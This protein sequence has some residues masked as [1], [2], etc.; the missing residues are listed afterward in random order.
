MNMNI[1]HLTDLHYGKKYDYNVDRM[2]PSLLKCL[3][4]LHSEN[5]IDFIVFSGDLIYS[6]S[7]SQYFSVVR[8]KIIL[9]LLD[10]LGLSIDQIFICAG[11]HD[12]NVEQEIP[13]IT[14]YVNK[15]DTND[16]LDEFYEDSKQFDLSYANSDNYF[17]FASD[18]YSSTDDNINKLSHVHL[19]KF[20]EKIIGFVS[21][22]TAWRSFIGNHSGE[23]LIP[24]K[25]VQDTIG[26][27]KDADFK[28]CLMHHPIS[29]LK[30]FNKYELETIITEKFHVLFTG[31]YHKKQQSIHLTHDFGLLSISS[32]ATMSGNDGSTIGFALLSIELD[33]YDVDIKNYTYA[34]ID[35]IFKETSSHL[36]QIPVND[37]KREQIKLLKEISR[38]ADDVIYDANDLLI[39]RNQELEEKN[40]NDIFSSPQLFNISF[41]ESIKD[42]GTA[43]TVSL[44]G[45]LEG[46]HVI[47]G[48]DKSGKS[49]LLRKLQI[50]ILRNFKQFRTIPIYIDCS[51]HSQIDNFD[52][53]LYCRNRF[54]LSRANT[55][56]LIKT[57]GF[58]LLLDNVNISSRRDTEFLKNITKIPFAKVSVILSTDESHTSYFGELRIDGISFKETFIHPINRTCIRSHANNLL[59]E[60]SDS[61]RN[62]IVERIVSVFS[63]LHIPFNYWTVS[64]FLW[65]YKKEKNLSIN[66]NVELINLYIDKL[67]GREEIALLGKDI[68]YKLIS[69]LL[70]DLS[71]ELISNH[72]D[73][74]YSMSYSDLVRFVEKFKENNIRFVSDEKNL[75]DHLIDKG[76]IKKKLDERYTFRLNGVMEYFTA[77]YMHEHAEFTSQII[78]DDNLFL[79]FTN[80]FEL[81]TGFDKSNFILLKKILEKT[82]IVLSRINTT[83][84]ENP[85][86]IIKTRLRVSERISKTI[87]ELDVKKQE[88]LSLEA[89]DEFQDNLSPIQHF[90]DEVRIKRP[91]NIEDG[92]FS[93]DQLQSYLLVLGRVLRGLSLIKDDAVSKEVFSFLLK[94]TIN[95]GFDLESLLNE[96]DE[97]PEH[98]VKQLLVEFVLN[99]IP[100]ITQMSFSESVSHA[101]IKRIAENLIEDLENSNDSHQYELFVLYF[102]LL[103]IDI[104]N[105]NIVSKILENI[106]IHALRSASIIKLTYYLIIKCANCSESYRNFLRDS[107]IELQLNVN[108][109]LDKGKLMQ[110]YK[111]LMQQ[112]KNWN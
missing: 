64:L 65:I 85:D 34:N 43:T 12:M 58:T 14:A 15:I 4:S 60:Y 20:N 10:E 108:S 87:S 75:I 29:D 19:R 103:D 46:N 101:N 63:Q 86:S 57:Y 7:E 67:L 71:Y 48:K 66:D 104:Q 31:H 24:R 13:A 61:E 102:M 106:N 8:T 22:N 55:D 42:S 2:F 23:L 69:R 82:K 89:Q 84:N 11:N 25:V 36:V 56:I 98:E 41:A 1:I 9:P 40:F 80:E 17:E 95:L 94:S 50:E 68:E 83:F 16:S 99:F 110:H 37:A 52:I 105:K 49:T 6:G 107:I 45:L 62:N 3:K 59:N 74:G 27:I 72:V 92:R 28:I 38:Y 39:F 90:N 79:E 93:H 112:N 51:L 111:K 97:K 5:P 18:F 70:G 54:S 33:T 35:N 32:P 44:I 53:N 81:L 47:Y 26:I 76:V 91:V 73:D 21:F 100:L 78:D 96:V 30:S 109:K 77:F 88:T